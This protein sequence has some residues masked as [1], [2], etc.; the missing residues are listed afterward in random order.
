MIIKEGSID[1]DSLI[2]KWEPL[3]MFYY[4]SMITKE[5]VTPVVGPTQNVLP[6]YEKNPFIANTDCRNRSGYVKMNPMIY[7]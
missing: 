6:L 1:S 7:N 2:G 3:K 4:A 5:P